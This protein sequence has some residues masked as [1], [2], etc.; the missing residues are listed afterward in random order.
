MPCPWIRRLNIV[1][2]TILPLIDKFK[3]I[4]AKIPARSCIDIDKLVLRFIWNGTG[5]RIAES[6][7][8]KSI[9]WKGSLC[10]MLRLTVQLQKSRYGGTGKRIDT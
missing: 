9:K 5:H 8:G 6:N 7:F 4:S 3:V 1:N 2:M 10:P